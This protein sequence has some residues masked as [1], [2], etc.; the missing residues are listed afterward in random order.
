MLKYFLAL[1]IILAIVLVALTIGADN[2][3]L[4][5]FKYIIS[6]SELQLSSLVAIIFGLGFILGWLLTGIFYLKL[7]FKNMALNR[8]VKRQTQQ[9]NEL[10]NSRDK[11]SN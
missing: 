4:I 10:T 2:D 3:Q 7:K 5:T 8:Q 6:Q 11:A 9:L 1:V